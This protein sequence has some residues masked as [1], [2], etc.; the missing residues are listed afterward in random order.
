ML[1]QENPFLLRNNFV[2]PAITLREKYDS[3]NNTSNEFQRKIYTYYIISIL[4]VFSLIK[5]DLLPP[6]DQLMPNI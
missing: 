3:V 5:V 4:K 6:F 2:I 1:L